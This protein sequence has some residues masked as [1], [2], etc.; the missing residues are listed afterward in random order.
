M[1]TRRDIFIGD[2]QGCWDAFN[3]LLDK[4]QFDPAADRLCLAGDLVNRG[5]KSLK[6]LHTVI[7]LGKPHFTVLGNHDLHLLAHAH[8][9]PEVRKPNPEFEKVLQHPEA[10]AI[11]GWL[12]AQPLLWLDKEQKIALVHAGIDPR[13]DREQARACAAEVEAALQGPDFGKFF[14]NMYGNQPNRW[15]PEQKRLTRLRTITNVLTRV[16]FAR[17]DGQL[18]LDS[19]GDLDH[20]PKH[21]RPWFE[22][23][24]PDW[25]RWSIVFGH[26]SMLGL[27]N[28]A[29]GQAICLDS[30]CVWG[31]ELTALVVEGGQRRIVQ[32]GC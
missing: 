13:W 2:L 26:W 23:L 22:L 28:H 19:S 20:P 7:E 15:L 10:E 16:R 14:E 24:H 4:L 31:G 32:V 30:G 25:K 21:C 27:H 5:G 1:Q 11:L 12:R 29:G 18:D 6:V 9:H 3:R 8:M 17:P